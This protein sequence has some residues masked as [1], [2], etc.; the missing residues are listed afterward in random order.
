MRVTFA[1]WSLAMLSFFFPIGSILLEPKPNENMLFAT[2]S[3]SSI[4]LKIW[5]FNMRNKRG[6]DW[7]NLILAAIIIL[8]FILL[9][10]N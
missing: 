4:L 1:F 10:F 7:T 5:R 2:T 8:F 3:L 6:E 9:F